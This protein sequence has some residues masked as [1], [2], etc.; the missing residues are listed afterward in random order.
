MEYCV[1]MS[2]IRTGEGGGGG[3]T[4]HCTARLLFQARA[5][6]S[7]AARHTQLPLC[8]FT[9]A[10][11]SGFDWPVNIFVSHFYNLFVEELD[12]LSDRAADTTLN[13]AQDVVQGLTALKPINTPLCRVCSRERERETASLHHLEDRPGPQTPSGWQPLKPLAVFLPSGPC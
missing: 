11:S 13:R 4:H 6:R 9:R 2:V 5:R 3:K 10:M 8:N 7:M 12:Y 1:Y